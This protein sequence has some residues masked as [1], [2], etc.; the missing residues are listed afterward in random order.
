MKQYVKSTLVLFCIC[1]AIAV[2]MALV[3]SFTAPIIEANENAAANEALTEVLPGGEG[4]VLADISDKTLPASVIE[5]YTENGGGYVI[6]L[7]TSGYAQGMTI[8]C[9]VKDGKIT[10]TKCLSSGETLGYEKTYGE[11]FVGKDEGGI[12]EVATVSGATKTT[13]AYKQAMLDAL[14]TAIIMGGGSV[15]IRTEEEILMDNL[16]AALPEANGEFEKLFFVEVVEGIDAV[17]TAKNGAGAVYQLGEYFV[18]VPAGSE[19]AESDFKA[20][21]DA[22]AAILNASV[23]EAVDLSAYEGL[24]SALLAASKTASGNYI[25]EVRGAGYGIQG[26]Y[27][28]S[29][30][31]IMI[32]VSMTADGTIIDTLTLSQ[33][34]SEGFGSVCAEEKFYG[35]FDGK[36]AENYK[37]ID[38]ISGATVTTNGYLKAMERAF[39][40]LEILK[41]GDTNEK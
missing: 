13:A 11:N 7:V 37:E 35:Q 28:A 31:Y 21:V 10:G 39:Q 12:S 34:E 25:L 17:Y 14:N 24:P 41:G 6:R 18:P 8:M 3:N 36:T 20:T 27:H 19:A 22:A 38:A 26:E 16:N 29:G 15:D 9:G 4:F 32:K 5:V 1:A 40:A 30:E 2:M 23:I 33:K